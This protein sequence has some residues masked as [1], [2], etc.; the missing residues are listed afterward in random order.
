MATPAKKPP[1]AAKAKAEKLSPDLKNQLIDAIRDDHQYLGNVIKRITIANA[2]AVFDVVHSN[3]QLAIKEREGP[4]KEAETR[5]ISKQHALSHYKPDEVDRLTVENAQLS[6]KF[7][8]EQIRQ[9]KRFRAKLEA[10]ETKLPAEMEEME[11]KTH[12]FT[13]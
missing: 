3:L 1:K 13:G 8:A 5:G 4:I 10:M 7:L 11:A 9:L 6:V 12:S 2:D